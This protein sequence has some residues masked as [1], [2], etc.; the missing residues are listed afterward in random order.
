MRN[1]DV[2]VNVHMDHVS[3]V[4]DVDYSPTGREFVSASFDKTIR[5]FPK[6]RGHSR[7]VWCGKAKGRER[8]REIYSPGS[9]K[10]ILSKTHCWAK[11]WYNWDL[12]WYINKSC[13]IYFGSTFI[14][15]CP[16]HTLHILTI[17]I[18]IKYAKLH[19]SNPKPNPNPNPNSRYIITLYKVHQRFFFCFFSSL[20]SPRLHLFDKKTTVKACFLFD[21][22]L[23]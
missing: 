16:C 7:W 9:H 23:V 12:F 6:N 3:A 19:A 15:R 22:K 10:G 1:L 8:E 20:R 14:L 4:L 11:V 21:Y 5:I 2:P 17:I 13:E 18:T